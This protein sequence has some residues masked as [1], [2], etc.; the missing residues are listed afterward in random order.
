MRHI[1]LDLHYW[2][3]TRPTVY[4]TKPIQRS[5]TCNLL[6]FVSV[7]FVMHATTAVFKQSSVTA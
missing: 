1:Q 3:N 5:R 4:A 6:A 2:I 7:F